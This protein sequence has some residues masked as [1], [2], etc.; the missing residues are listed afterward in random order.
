MSKEL[1]RLRDKGFL[2]ENLVV[3]L[4]VGGTIKKP[5]IGLKKGFI[6]GLTKDFLKGDAL[7]GLLRGG[8]RKLLGGD[9]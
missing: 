9:D 4:E 3:P 8:L 6:T 5:S 7:D 2:D 1:D